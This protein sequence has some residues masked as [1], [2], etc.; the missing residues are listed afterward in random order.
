MKTPQFLYSLARL[1]GVSILVCFLVFATESSPVRIWKQRP[2]VETTPAVRS[3][4]KTCLCCKKTMDRLRKRIQQAGER[5][6][7][8]QKGSTG[9][10]T[11][12]EP[13]QTYQRR[14]K[15]SPEEFAQ[16]LADQFRAKPT[17]YSSSLERVGSCDK[18]S[19]Q[20]FF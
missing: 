18:R 4:K 6:R 1:A 7:K 3:E 8:A 15:M 11:Q 2:P 9:R 5:K 17:V 16:H 14:S 20:S 10:L 13:P 19:F 12:E